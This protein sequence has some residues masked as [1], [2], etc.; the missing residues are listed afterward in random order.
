MGQATCEVFNIV[1]ASCKC[2]D[3]LREKHSAEVIEVLKNNEIST[4]RGL[5]QEMSLKRP[6]DTCW[7]SHYGALVTLIHMFSSVIDVIETIIEDGLD[8][9]QRAETNILIGFLQTFEFMFDLHLMKGVLGISNELSQA[10]QQEDQ[11]IVNAMKLV[12]I[13]KKRL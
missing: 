3:I 7:S 12:D 9:D 4:G 1:E 5:N 10:L 6:R 2:C 13:S 8:S 11:I